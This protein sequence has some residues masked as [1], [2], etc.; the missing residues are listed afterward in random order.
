MAAAR[1][2]L[3]RPARVVTKALAI[4]L[5]VCLAA[6]AWQTRRVHA[7]QLAAATTAAQLAGAQA[8]AERLARETNTA[9]V[10]TMFNAGDAYD[11]GRNDA[12]AVADRTIAGLNAGT[13]Q[14]RRE[15]AGCETGRLADG[16][17]ARREIDDAD[18][19]RNALAGRIVR[20]G[21][22]CDALQRSLITAYDGLRR[23]IN[24]ARP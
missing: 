13:L 4:A 16:A 10:D 24:E 8:K 17:A 7:L 3:A 18:Q 14:L 22:E 6:L 12:Q 23:T 2:P 19:R 1:L 20:V 9:L 5:A 15:W 11:R 21:A